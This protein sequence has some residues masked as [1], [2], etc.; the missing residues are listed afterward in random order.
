MVRRAH[1]SCAPNNMYSIKYSPNPPSVSSNLRINQKNL[2]AYLLSSVADKGCLSRI[3]IFSSRIQ[4]QKDS[5]SRIRILIKEFKYFNPKNFYGT[6]HS[7]MM[8]IPDPDLDFLPIPDPGVKKAPDP[9]SGTATLYIFKILQYKYC[10]TVLMLG[11][12][13]YISSC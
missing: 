1:S 11:C 2:V 12:F 4:G 6:M 10:N 3:R 13:R 5:G 7:E 9:R 8:F